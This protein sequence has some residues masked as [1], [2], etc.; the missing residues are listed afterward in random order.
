MAEDDHELTVSDPGPTPEHGEVWIV[1]DNEQDFVRGKRRPVVVVQDMDRWS[2]RDLD[3]VIVCPLTTD[4]HSAPYR[5]PVERSEANGLD[6]HSRLMV[7]KVT[8]MRKAGFVKRIG[9]LD[10]DI[11]RDFYDRLTLFMIPEDFRLEPS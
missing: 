5:I 7:D 10:E 11:L 1:K 2:S 3:S 8:S 9:T 4:E 6:E